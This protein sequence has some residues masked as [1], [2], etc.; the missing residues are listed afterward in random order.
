MKSAMKSKVMS[1]KS[2]A[3]AKGGSG[4]MSGKNYAGMQKPGQSASMGQKSNDKPAKGGGAKM[5]GFTGARS[6][7]KV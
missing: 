1:S 3:F 7:K 6:A 2:G 4:K 5:A